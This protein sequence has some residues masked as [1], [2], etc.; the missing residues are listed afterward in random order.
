MLIAV[1]MHLVARLVAGRATAHAEPHAERVV[2]REERR[3]Q[4][5]PAQQHEGR[6]AAAERL[7]DD[8]VLGE[9]PRR[10]WEAREAEA[11][12]Q[13]RPADHAEALHIAKPRHLAEVE[14]AG[15]AVHDRAA[16]EEE[17]RL[18]ERMREHVVHG[19][20]RGSHAQPEEHVPEL[21]HRRVRH[22]PLDVVLGHADGG[23]DERRA[24]ADDGHHGERVRIEQ[25]ERIGARDQIDARRDHGRRMDEG[26]HRCRTLHGVGK[27][28]E[29]GDLRA[30]AEG[31]QHEAVGD[32]RCRPAG[33]RAR[34][35][36]ASGHRLEERRVLH[37]TVVD[38]DEEHAEREAEV[39]HPVHDEGLLGGRHGARA[40]VEVA[41]EQVTGQSDAFPSEVQQDE[42]AAHHQRAH[43]EQEDAH[44]AEEP[45]VALA[46]VRLH[47]LG[48]VDRDEGSESRH[49]QH[50]QQCERI[51][52]ER[53][54]REETRP[55]GADARP[56]ERHPV[57]EMDHA[58]RVLRHLQE[59]RK[60][61]GEGREQRDGGDRARQLVAHAHDGAQS[62]EERRERRQEQDEARPSEL[63]RGYGRGNRD[64]GGRR[65]LGQ[66]GGQLQ[67]EVR[68]TGEFRHVWD[69]E[70]G[71][72]SHAR[73][74]G[75]RARQALSRS[76][77]HASESSVSRRR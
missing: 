21:R 46:D 72:C 10:E 16:A 30:L 38:P 65:N 52:V 44:G 29:Q 62:A 14:L 68:E 66:D 15:H 32:E 27:P 58:R 77:L 42:V 51:D 25:E 43:G 24:A 53:E 64:L 1:A 59:E 56:G 8:R 12:D 4:R 50:P 70:I 3:E 23:G 11:A 69:S 7:G 57:E 5:D 54:R 19:A 26:R 48:C 34:R 63:G 2:G 49:E 20:K 73:S 71:G 33:F 18:E 47:V 35:R 41:D 74:G 17:Q 40:L 75:C 37:R 39:A 60:R 6:I 36:L 31:S 55:R 9:E 61:R 13:E 67:G 45:R 28:D 22:H 76:S